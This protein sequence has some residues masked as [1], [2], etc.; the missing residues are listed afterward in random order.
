MFKEL[1][2]AAVASLLEPYAE[3]IRKLKSDNETLLRRVTAL[4]ARPDPFDTRCY[5]EERLEELDLKREAP[6]AEEVAE[7][8]SDRALA[9]ALERI[10]FSDSMTSAAQDWMADQ[11]WSS[12]VEEALS[13]GNVLDEDSIQS[14]IS[15]WLDSD[16]GQ[17]RIDAAVKL[18]VSGRTVELVLK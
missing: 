16:A 10:D 18:V 17:E 13:G 12:E 2:D 14:H 11:D 1:I 6:S 9:K 3:E 4:E 15:K 8:I 5:I 7:A